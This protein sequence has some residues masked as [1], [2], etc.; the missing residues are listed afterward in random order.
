VERVRGKEEYTECYSRN[1]RDWVTLLKAGF[2]ELI[3]MR[4]RINKGETYY[5][6]N[7]QKKKKGSRIFYAPCG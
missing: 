5:Y 2:Y 3:E 4:K 1:G 6:R 7:I